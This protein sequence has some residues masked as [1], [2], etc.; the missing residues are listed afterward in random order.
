MLKNTQYQYGLVSTYL[1]WLSALLIVVLFAL[2]FWMVEL[3]YYNEWYR[4]GPYY[5]K[6]LGL[7]LFALSVTRVICK[8]LQPKPIIS[9][10]TAIEKYLAQLGHLVLYLSLF[11]ILISGYL[12]S[13]ADGRGIEVFGLF[14]VPSVGELFNN[15]EDIAGEIHR[16]AAY[17]I[18][19]MAL[20]HA[21]AAL[22]H[23]F[24]N[25]DD[26]LIKMTRFF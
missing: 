4:L 13:T 26:T 15:Q 20:V 3:S 17:F 7:L 8:V 22:R 1:H 14:T 9:S 6:S 11:C 16:Y 10:A 23:H 21:L 25:K 24:I 12:I 18:I 5:H 2:G 19:F